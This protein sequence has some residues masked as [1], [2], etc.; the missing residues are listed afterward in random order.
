MKIKSS[1]VCS[2][3]RKS[4]AR[5]WLIEL[6]I[7]EEPEIDEDLRTGFEQTTDFITVVIN[8]NQRILVELLRHFLI[9]FILHGTEFSEQSVK[10]DRYLLHSV[11][12]LKI[13]T[14]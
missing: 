11:W 3:R 14:H 12:I 7:R 1:S 5:A 13:V 9:N 8:V 10:L 4:Q 2:G 6:R